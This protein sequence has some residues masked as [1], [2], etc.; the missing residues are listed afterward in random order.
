MSNFESLVTALENAATTIKEETHEGANNAERIGNAFQSVVD[1]LRGISDFLASKVSSIT[2][3]DNTYEGQN[4]TL[5]YDYVKTDELRLSGR[6]L[7]VGNQTITIPNASISSRT[8]T[9][10]NHSVEVPQITLNS[11]SGIL[12]VG[13]TQMTL[14][15]TSDPTVPST[16][17]S[18]YNVSTIPAYNS[19][20]DYCYISKTAL[21]NGIKNI[22]MEAV[23]ASFQNLCDTLS[24][25][26]IK[27]T[28]TPNNTGN[29]FTSGFGVRALK[30]RTVNILP[31]GDTVLFG[32]YSSGAWDNFVN[33]I[34]HI[35][36]QAEGSRDRKLSLLCESVNGTLFCLSYD[37]SGYFRTPYKVSELPEGVEDQIRATAAFFN[38]IYDGV[39]GDTVNITSQSISG[40]T[41]KLRLEYCLFK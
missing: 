21:Q 28:A 30:K 23:N 41:G 10:D 20:N 33:P 38:T 31:D 15:K 1:T 14:P 9:I 19:S 36:R 13:T 4:I 32:N 40:V 24:S 37:G 11:S 35:S 39:A 34:I 2:I 27:I 22:V 8:I 12:T 5:P 18:Y 29:T 25:S 26:G 7:T 16:S 17:L 3:G 6:N